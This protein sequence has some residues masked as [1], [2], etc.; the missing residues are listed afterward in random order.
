MIEHIPWLNKK[1]WKVKKSSWKFVYKCMTFVIMKRKHPLAR[2]LFQLRSAEYEILWNLTGSQQNF[3][4][5]NS[6][7]GE[8]Y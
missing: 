4:C 7:P 8:I 2:I 5:K 6:K 1:R 3:R